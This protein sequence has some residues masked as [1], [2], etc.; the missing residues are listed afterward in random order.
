[1][2]T[3]ITKYN[4]VQPNVLEI[5]R[6]DAGEIVI[7]SRWNSFAWRKFHAWKVPKEIPRRVYLRTILRYPRLVSHLTNDYWPIDA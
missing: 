1:M 3:I 2:Q 7:S 6:I 5:L 4:N